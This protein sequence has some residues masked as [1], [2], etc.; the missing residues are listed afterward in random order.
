[1][2]APLIHLLALLPLL[3][4]TGCI[5]SIHYGTE[6]TSDLAEVGAPEKTI[7]EKHGAP[8]QLIP[9]SGARYIYVY[10]IAE[11][12]VILDVVYGRDAFRNIAY[13]V[14]GGKITGVGVADEGSG[15]RVLRS[16]VTPHPKARDGHGG[17]DPGGQS[18]L[19]DLLGVFD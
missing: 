16:A 3:A 14:D 1:M 18:L 8:D 15:L 12:R 9:V 7:I 19:D 17:D 11:G 10:R 5:S 13:M 2:R 6:N 4:V